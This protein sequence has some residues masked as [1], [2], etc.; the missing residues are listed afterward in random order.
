MVPVDFRERID[1]LART[2]ILKD[3]EFV[4]IPKK[5]LLESHQR[6]FSPVTDEALAQ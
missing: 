6:S 1:L 3:G 5:L 2:S 4:P